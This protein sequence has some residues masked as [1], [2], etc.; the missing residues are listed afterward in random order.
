MKKIKNPWR[1]KNGYFCFGCCPENESGVKMEFYA[2]GE[3]V[4]CRW[5]PEARF[6][7]WI[8]TLHGGIQALLID[9]ICAW[10]VSYK[11]NTT[12]VTM[13]METR[14]KKPV[15]TTDEYLDLKARVTEQRRNVVTVEAT[16][17]NSKGEVC[18][19]G[20]CIYYA[21]P[22]EKAEEMGLTECELGPEIDSFD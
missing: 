11:L 8:D 20:L 4:L 13:K 12:G 9:E 1:G 19:E 7:G 5:K 3:Y 15:L 22:K 21:F 6:Q 18:T 17:C 14:Y 16:L 2:E 10:A